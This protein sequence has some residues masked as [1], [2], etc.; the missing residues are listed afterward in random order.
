MGSVSGN[1]HSEKWGAS[2]YTYKLHLGFYSYVLLVPLV[3]RKTVLDDSVS[4][5]GDDNDAVND[6]DG[7]PA[8]HN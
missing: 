7:W 5:A 3:C 2:A 8:V 4:N 6:S 1:V